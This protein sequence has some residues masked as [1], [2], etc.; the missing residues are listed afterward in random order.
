MQAGI[1]LKLY[2]FYGTSLVKN[3]ASKTLLGLIDQGHSSRG[4]PADYKQCKYVEY[5]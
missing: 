5:F 4:Y 2:I 3:T 1:L